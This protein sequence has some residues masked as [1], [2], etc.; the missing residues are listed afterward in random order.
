[1]DQWIS[2]RSGETWDDTGIGFISDMFPQLIEASE[3]P[4]VYDVE[5][6]S[7]PRPKTSETSR[8]WFPT[9]LLNLDIKK[10]VAPNTH[11]LFT[12]VLAKRVENGRYDLEVIIMDETGDV[13]AL[14]N[15][16]CLVLPAGRNLAQ[17]RQKEAGADAKDAAKL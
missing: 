8:Y 7:S 12:R 13:I 1:M 16:V 4:S 17:R 14:S 5:E 10:P 9:L 15:H 3:N 6:S 11:F 2:L